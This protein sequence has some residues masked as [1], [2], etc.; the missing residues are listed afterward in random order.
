MV[1]LEAKRLK[2]HGVEPHLIPKLSRV[3]GESWH[4]VFPLIALV[5]MLLLDFTPFL[6]AFWGIVLCFVCSYIPL[7]ARK[8]GWGEL[9]GQTLTWKPLIEGLEVGAKYAL[10]IG[11]ACACVGLILGTLTLSGLGFKFSGAV[12]ELAAQVCR[13]VPRHRSVQPLHRDRR[14]DL[15]RPAVRRHRVH[16]DGHRRP[17]DADVHHPRVDRRA[18][19]GYARRAA[20][21]DALLRLLLRRARG[22]DATGGPRRVRGGRA[23]RAR[24][25]CARGSPPSAC[26]WARRSCRSCSS[27]RRACCSSTSSGSAF[28]SAMFCGVVGIVALSAAYIGYFRAPRHAPRRSC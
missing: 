14:Q 1:H 3:I 8:M 12:I 11:A 19:A 16:P 5:T 6:S 23:S 24:S 13:W 17:D 15:L 9:Q 28:A 18:G 10:A 21:R 27:T 25:R 7:I 4:L 20:D 2:L 22:R 26:R